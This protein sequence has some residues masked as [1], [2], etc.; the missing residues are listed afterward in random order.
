VVLRRDNWKDTKERP[1]MPLE[2]VRDIPVGGFYGKSFMS[3]IIPTNMQTEHLIKTMFSN[4]QELDAFGILFFPTSSGLNVQ[5]LKPKKGGEPRVLL[6]EPDL[7]VPQHQPFSIKPENM[8]DWPGKVAQMGMS[9]INDLAGQSPMMSGNAPGRVDS[10]QGLGM[11]YEA[12]TVSLAAP[13]LSLANGFC[14]VYKAL[15]GMAREQWEKGTLAKVTMLD[16]TLVGVVL[17]G[18][19]GKISLDKNSIP[20]PTQ[21]TVLVKSQMPRSIAQRKSEMMQM[22][23]SGLIT[24]RE[25][26]R[27]NMVEGLDFPQGSRAEYENWRKAVLNNII[28]FGDGMT[29]GDVIISMEADN[30]E[31]QLEAVQDFMAKP[32]F[33]LASPEVRTAFEKRKQTYAQMLGQYP[34]QLPYP[35]QAAEIQDQVMPDQ[36]EGQEQGGEMM[37]Q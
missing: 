9:I 15:L 22:L 32:E 4:A 20:H 11:L 27:I 36:G 30:P 2:V 16:D 10:A 28:Q 34:Q 24:P 5:S 23:Q 35:E 21:V 33:T 25:F 6:Y 17:D 26:R 3:L 29:P 13:M 37:Q 19:T 12:S 1:M 18:A 14:T 8:G 7:T 31:I